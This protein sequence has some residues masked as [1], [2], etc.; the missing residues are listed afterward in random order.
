MSYWT[1]ACTSNR[2]RNVAGKIL[3]DQQMSRT[4]LKDVKR[5]AS[6]NANTNNNAPPKRVKLTENFKSTNENIHVNPNTKAPI[7]RS[8]KSDKSMEVETKKRFS[9]ESNPYSADVHMSQFATE[10]RNESFTIKLMSRKDFL[11]RLGKELF[12][13]AISSTQQ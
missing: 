1:H 3:I 13:K 7:I 9:F 12:G 2:G 4:T 8:S 10:V 5:G 6:K 11:H